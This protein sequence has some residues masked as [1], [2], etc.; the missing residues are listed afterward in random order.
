[1]RKTKRETKIK[2]KTTNKDKNEDKDKDKG[3]GKGKDTDKDKDKDTDKDKDDKARQELPVR[4]AASTSESATSALPQAFT[5]RRV[6]F[7][8]E[9][10]IRHK[11]TPN[12]QLKSKPQTLILT[13]KEPNRNK[14]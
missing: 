13:H 11:Q 4:T 6:R 7:R 9:G 12:S 10:P 2:T 1:V 14:T 3:K 8:Y 5:I